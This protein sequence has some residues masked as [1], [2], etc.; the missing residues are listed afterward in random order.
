MLTFLSELALLAGLGI[1]PA[2]GPANRTPDPAP[3][4][5][6]VAAVCCDVTPAPASPPPPQGTN[7]GWFTEPLILGSIVDAIN[8]RTKNEGDVTTG[9]YLKFGA[10]VPGAGWIATGPGY[11]HLFG[12]RLLFDAS[13]TV[14]WRRYLNGR[15][16]LELRPLENGDL[17]VGAQLL[18]QDWTQ[19][20]YFGL[21]LKSREE[22]RSLYRLRAA[23]VSAYVTVSPGKI[24]DVRG[25]VGM[26]SRPR[27]TPAAGWNKGDYPDTQTLLSGLPDVAAPGLTA[28]PKFLHADIS[29]STDTRDHPGHP[30]RGFFLEAAA[31]QFDDRDLDRFSFRRYEATAIAFVPIVGNRWTLGARATAIK[32]TTSGTNEVPFYMMPSLG[33][34]VLRGFETGRF[35]DRNLIAL[36][37]ESRWAIYKHMDVAVFGDFGAVAPRFRALNTSDRESSVGVGLRLHT[38]ADTFFRLD[39]ARPSGGGWRMVVKLHESLES[40]RLQRWNTI[41]PVVR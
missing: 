25:R 11:R 8:S 1:G 20:N 32:T 13:G 31:A 4:P 30:T 19:V 35:Q 18:A 2:Q 38:G 37:L 12:E 10:G 9:P 14:S 3:T 22:D 27:I 7:K 41:V 40:A 29:V 15:A 24:V 26:L 17:A 16:R 33:Q 23:D 6:P 21:G 28:Q 39:M 36:N 5:A 34:A